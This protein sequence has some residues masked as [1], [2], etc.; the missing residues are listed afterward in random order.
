MRRLDYILTWGVLIT[1]F[2]SFTRKSKSKI[3]SRACILPLMQ[4]LLFV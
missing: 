2:L 4:S 1:S 3:C